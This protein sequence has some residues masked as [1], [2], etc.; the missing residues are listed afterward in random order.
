[1]TLKDKMKTYNFWISLVSAILLLVRVI[2]DKYGFSVDAGLVMDITTGLCGIFVIL[3]IISAP[4]KNQS[5]QTGVSKGEKV[6]I[7]N[8]GNMV[9]GDINADETKAIGRYQ[10]VFLSLEKNLETVEAVSDEK[11]LE[12]EPMKTAAIEIEENDN[13]I[14]QVDE[15][16]DKQQLE[17][18]NSVKQADCNNIVQDK[19]AQINLA[20]DESDVVVKEGEGDASINVS[21]PII[22][23]E[24]LFLEQKISALSIQEKEKLL[25]LLK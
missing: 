19:D 18:E 4:Q 12:L 22:D 24:I 9:T 8:E 13:Y 3:G 17:D 21:Q 5:T 2:G 1:M 7:E 6:M 14:M 16:K 10:N 20:L 11:S 23:D 15:G 25:S